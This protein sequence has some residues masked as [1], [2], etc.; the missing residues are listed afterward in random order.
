MA[1]PLRS[2]LLIPGKV[3]RRWSGNVLDRVEAQLD[4]GKIG[5]IVLNKA[6]G[7]IRVYILGECR[8]TGSDRTDRACSNRLLSAR[9]SGT[10]RRRPSTIVYFCLSLAEVGMFCRL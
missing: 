8:L 4:E 7:M 9:H 3:T 1:F 10:T 6:Q 5:E 2:R